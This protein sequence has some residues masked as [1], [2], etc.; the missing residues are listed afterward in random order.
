M[1]ARLHING[2]TF[3]S[4]RPGIPRVHSHRSGSSF[5]HDIGTELSIR[6]LQ[7]ANRGASR[8]SS[9]GEMIETGSYPG[10]HSSHFEMLIIMSREGAGI[11]RLRPIH[12]PTIH[13]LLIVDIRHFDR[14]DHGCHTPLVVVSM[15]KLLLFDHLLLI[16][17]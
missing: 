2:L 7:I 11:D 10:D 13:I 4:G 12:R 17:V 9:R 14:I 6:N 16:F 15:R 3:M 5:L 8:G 1:W